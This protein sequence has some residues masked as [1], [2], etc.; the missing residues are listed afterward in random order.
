MKISVLTLFPEMLASLQNSP[1]IQHAQNK[2][3][4]TLEIVDIRRFADGSFRHLDDSPFGGGAGM[5]LR[6]EPVYRAL[7]S[8]TSEE[9]HVVIPS[10]V[11]IP[12]SQKK[13]RELAEK[14]DLILICGHYEGMDE[15]IYS[16]CDERLSMG[17]YILSGGEYAAMT[18]ADSVVRLLDGVIRKESTETESFENGLLEYPQY[19]KPVEFEGM[20][21]PEVLRS[22]NHEAIRQF[23]LKES[24]CATMKYRKDLLE[25][26]ELNEEEK[27]I[28][29]ELKG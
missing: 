9:S 1:I 14:R 4:L 8:I 7:Q 17:D 11:G 24:L 18:I 10:P 15:R 25:K 19:T 16:F 13:A 22:G 27:Q 6:V 28:L 5:I 2:G 29:N 12:Y 3:I 21:V 26:Y 20:K 23:R